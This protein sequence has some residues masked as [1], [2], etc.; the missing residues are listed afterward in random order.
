MSGPKQPIPKKARFGKKSKNGGNHNE[1]P[2]SNGHSPKLCQLCAKHSPGCKNTHNTAQC[3]KWNAD[4]TDKRRAGQ[5]GNPRNTNAHSHSE[6]D[7]KAV[8]VQTRKEIKALK[9]LTKKSRKKK[10]RKRYYE[11]SEDS[12]SSDD[13]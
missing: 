3:C 8:F 11:F 9:K 6:E 13:E 10:S 5:R 2:P 1:G 12:D 4:G 7:T